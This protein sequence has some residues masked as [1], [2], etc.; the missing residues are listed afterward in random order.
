MS[1][2]RSA[3]VRPL[4]PR[5]SPRSGRHADGTFARR[6]RVALTHGGRSRQVREAQLPG[7]VEVRV[8]RADKRAAILADLGGESQVSQLQQDL[9]DRYVEL[10]TVAAWLGGH[11]VAHGPLTAKGRHR[12]A[13]SAYVSV[14]DRVHRLATAL[15][16][17]R[18]PRPVRD[19][20]LALTQAPEA[21]RV[22]PD[23][24]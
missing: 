18:R 13:L 5:P 1:P 9:I 10:D 4:P 20:A 6:N 2:K 17:A 12:A 21:N 24:D 16:L 7:Q 22:S 14:V 3:D 8:Q 19:L 15:G 11:L 23:V